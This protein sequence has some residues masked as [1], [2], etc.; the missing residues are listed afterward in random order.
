MLLVRKDILDILVILDILA[1]LLVHRDIRDKSIIG[2]CYW[3]AQ[4]EEAI[5]Q[6]SLLLLNSP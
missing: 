2:Q 3:C 4:L 5:W 6:P 1:M